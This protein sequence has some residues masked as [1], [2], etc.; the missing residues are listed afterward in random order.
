MSDPRKLRVI[1]ETPA[2][3]VMVIVRMKGDYMQ[4]YAEGPRT[5]REFVRAAEPNERWDLHHGR[6]VGGP[7]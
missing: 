4:M 3:E 1:V 6:F 2:G 7:T 5:A